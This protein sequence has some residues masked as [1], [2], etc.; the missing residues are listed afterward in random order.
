MRVDD[1]N[2]AGLGAARSGQAAETQRTGSDGRAGAGRAGND[3]DRVELSSLAGRLSYFLEAGAQARASRVSQ[4]AADVQGGR[5]RVDSA[6]VSRAM[7]DDALEF[8]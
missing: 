5:Y 2:L 8:R 3:A 4:L 1:R 6:A 7:L